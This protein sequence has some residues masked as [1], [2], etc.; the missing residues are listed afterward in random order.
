MADCNPGNEQVGS[1]CRVGTEAL[2][3]RI[4]NGAEPVTM[5]RVISQLTHENDAV[6]D[7]ER[8]VSL[9]RRDVDARLFPSPARDRM[10]QKPSPDPAR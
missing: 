4:G 9:L 8:A 1:R 10:I 5:G 7:Q 6:R 2:L 3:Q